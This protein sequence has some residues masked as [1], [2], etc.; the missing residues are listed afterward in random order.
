MPKV[1]EIGAA[2]F[3]T[4]IYRYWP[5]FR[6]NELDAVVARLYDY[7]SRRGYGERWRALRDAVSTWRFENP[8]EFTNRDELPAANGICSRLMSFLG[9]QHD[10]ASALPYT[11]ACELAYSSRT[12]ADG[13]V[14]PNVTPLGRSLP[15]AM[16]HLS[17]RGEISAVLLIDMQMREAKCA[18]NGVH[19]TYNELSVL[20]NQC[21]VLNTAV[22]LRVPI[23]NVSIQHAMRGEVPPLLPRLSL[24]LRGGDVTDF[25]KASAN[26]FENTD[27]DTRLRRHRV[28]RVQYVVAMGWDANICVKN[29]IF[30][31]PRTRTNPRHPGLLERQYTVLTSRAVLA[32]SVDAPLESPYRIEGYQ[33]ESGHGLPL[34]PFGPFGGLD[35]F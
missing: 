21:A 13:R 10:P 27:L 2:D 32:S 7:E 11:D 19:T 33:R 29:T 24:C 35:G 17:A 5:R 22:E 8:K 23:F 15:N 3:E 25:P 9:L 30:S 16:R 18:E 1:D 12:D 26:C 14:E 20:E 28:G 6:S 34:T 31:T 4:R